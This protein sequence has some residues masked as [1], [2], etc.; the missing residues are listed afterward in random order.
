[1]NPEVPNP[2]KITLPFPVPPALE[3]W[4]PTIIGAAIALGIFII[5]WI[6]SKW[7]Y[8]LVLRVLRNRSVDE[9]VSRFLAGMAQYAVLAAAVITALGKVGVPTTSLVALLGTAGLAVGLALQGSLSHFAAGVMT[10]LFR[11]YTI[12]D[13]ITTAGHTGQV[14][15]IGLFATT[16]LTPDND[17]I[18]VPNG[19]AT[20]SSIVNHSKLGN[21]RANISI[22]V[23]YGTDIEKALQV[24][25]DCLKTTEKVL[26]EPAP[27]CAFGGFGA[28]SLDLL[29]RPYA[30][31]GDYP[32]MQHNARIS[33]Y[34]ALNNAGIEIPFDQIVVH[35]E[36]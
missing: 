22:G 18:I 19:E 5:G 4:V 10:L 15:E 24:I 26:E 12:G 7:A 11:P 13:I 1:M 14:E 17:T 25:T 36:S 27:S 29:A 21:R 16:M 31:P 28:S 9:A 34:N 30:L 33:I 8:S 6:V 32:G 35:Q 20:S 3:P 23:A 2:A